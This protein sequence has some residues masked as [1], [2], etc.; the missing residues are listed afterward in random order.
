MSRGLRRYGRRLFEIRAPLVRE[1]ILKFLGTC[2]MSNTKMDL[3]VAETLC[4]KLSEVRRRITWRQFILALVFH[5]D[6]EMAETGFGPYWL[7]HFRLVSNQGLRG[8]SVVTRELSLIDL[9]KLKRLKIYVRVDDTWA[10]VALRPERQLDAAASS[11]RAAEDALTV[12]EGGGAGAITEHYGLRGDV[13]RSITDQGRF[14][15][16]MDAIRR[17]LG[18]R[19][20]HIDLLYRPCCKEIN[21]M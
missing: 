19:I 5:T 10:W 18:F 21:D 3:D 2:R 17:I 4:F 13:D 1:F 14:T 7:A 12:D 16:W 11:P 8:L 20:H 15:T 6:E 9:N